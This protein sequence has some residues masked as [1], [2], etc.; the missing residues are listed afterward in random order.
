MVSKFMK[1]NSAPLWCSRLKVSYVVNAAIIG[2]SFSLNAAPPSDD[3]V[4][5]Y[6]DEFNANAVNEADW[7]Y[8]FYEK[9]ESFWG[10]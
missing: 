3:Y 10:G 2:L 7:Y 9:P 5:T 8:R 1:T 4:L 6:A